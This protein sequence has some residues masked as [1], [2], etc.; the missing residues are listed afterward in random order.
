MI[1]KNHYLQKNKKIIFSRNLLNLYK[2]SLFCIDALK[3]GILKIP[4]IKHRPN[5]Y[6]ND[7]PKQINVFLIKCI[8]V[9]L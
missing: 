6:N 3:E 2:H 9:F 5:G 7:N 1:N 8:C 4:G